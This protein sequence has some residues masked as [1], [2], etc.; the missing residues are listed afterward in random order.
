[1]QD[2]H[3]EGGM[4]KEVARVKQEE[5]KKSTPAVSRRAHKLL[6]FFLKKEEDR[7]LS[8]LT[9]AMQQFLLDANGK[10]CNY[11]V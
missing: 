11:G 8:R 10:H 5:K 9:Y 1:M 3:L 4:K 6:F 2:R 7:S